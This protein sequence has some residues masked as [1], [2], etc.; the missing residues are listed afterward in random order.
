MGRQKRKT[1][2]PLQKDDGKNP[3]TSEMENEDEE[4]LYSQSEGARTQREMS[5][6]KEFIRSENVRNSKALAEEI[7]RCTDQRMT[8]LESSLSFALTANETLAKRLSEAEQRARRAED[9]LFQCAKRLSAVEEQVDDVMQRERQ[10]W[11]LFSGPAV[12]QTMNAGRNRDEKHLLRNLLEKHMG[13]E[14]DEN[15]VG[16]IHREQRQIRVRF[17]TVTAGSARYFLVRNKTR[18]RGSGLY[19]REYLTPTRQR[20]FNAMLN[21]KRNNQVSTVFTKEG[22]VFAVIDHRD[23]PCPIRSEAAVERVV[24]YLSEQTAERPAGTLTHQSQQQGTQRKAAPPMITN[25]GGSSPPS[26]DGATDAG[27]AGSSPGTAGQQSPAPEPVGTGNGTQREQSG[28]AAEGGVTHEGGTPSRGPVCSPGQ[29]QLEGGG[30]PGAT[31]A[32]S[33]PVDRAV[34]AADS[35]AGDSGE[36]SSVGVVLSANELTRRP[37]TETTPTAGVR[38]R[39]GGDIRNFVTGYGKHSK[40]D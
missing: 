38:R 30:Y 7:R 40:R 24:Q 29:G 1:N 12:T 36:G 22:T 28:P 25:A 35:S 6:L 2:S 3:R 21:L 9:E 13:Y 10:A 11:L 32:G 20:I 5:E 16:E 14:L 27:R 19:I 8:A 18:L 17:N 37:P 34:S 23:R 39:F 4:S 15:Q 31:P 26:A 33:A